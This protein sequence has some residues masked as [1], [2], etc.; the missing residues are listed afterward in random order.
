[1]VL[2]HNL[3]VKIVRFSEEELEFLYKNCDVNIVQSLAILQSVSREVADKIVKLI[4]NFRAI[5]SR[6]D[7]AE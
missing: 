2:G 7:A 5:K 3:P 6:L 4:E 1:M